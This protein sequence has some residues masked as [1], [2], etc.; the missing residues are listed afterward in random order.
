MAR[1]KR[2]SGAVHGRKVV[3]TDETLAGIESA[4]ERMGMTQVDML[5][6]LVRWFA[7]LE[8]AA[9]QLVVGTLPA[10]Y[11]GDAIARLCE[12][13][14]QGYGLRSPPVGK[15]EKDGGSAAVKRP[16]RAG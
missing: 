16:S 4:R 6:R 1:K 12:Q 9:Q 10:E 15:T 2:D 11:A 14:G 13:L 5:T 7:G 3:L 8:P